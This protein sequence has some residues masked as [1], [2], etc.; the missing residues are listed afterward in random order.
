MDGPSK[1]LSWYEVGCRDGTPY[2]VEWR[3]TRLAKLASVFEQ[4]RAD[5]GEA[6][7]VLSAYRTP[8]YN[9]RVKGARSSQHVEGRA[10]DLTPL[11]KPVKAFQDFMEKKVSSYPAIRGMGFYPWGVHIDIRESPSLVRW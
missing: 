8:E 4:I 10:L 2:P 6:L 5:W 3:E 11:G 9:K 1:H 7:I